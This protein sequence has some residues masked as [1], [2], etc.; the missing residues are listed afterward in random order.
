QQNHRGVYRSF[1]GADSWERIENGLPLNATGT[2]FGFPMAMHPHDGDTL[3]V[4]PQESDE[5]RFAPDGRL[6][7]YRTTDAGDSWQATTRG[8]PDSAY[9][10]VLRQAMATD[11]LDEPGVY[12]GTSAGDVFCSTDGGESWRALPCR[13]PRISSVLAVTEA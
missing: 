7:V 3:F 8:L 2:C 9:V 10:G 5:Y 12:F 6:A 1:D 11:T 13:L 4:V